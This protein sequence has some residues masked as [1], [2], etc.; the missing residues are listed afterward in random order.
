V[1]KTI[2]HKRIKGRDY[3]YLNYRKNG[4]F[5]S[6]YLGKVDSPR[7]KRFLLKLIS[8]QP[9]SAEKFARSQNFKAGVPIAYV[10]GGILTLEYKNGTKVP[11]HS[12]EPSK[13]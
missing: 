10:E 6:E 5:M 7:F 8:D 4:I 2:S 13:L 9:S 1:K 11:S 3:Y 12:K